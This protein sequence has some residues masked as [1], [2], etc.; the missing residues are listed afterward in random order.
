MPLHLKGLKV[1]LGKFLNARHAN[2]AKFRQRSTY[3]RTQLMHHEKWK[4]YTVYIQSYIQSRSCIC[5]IHQHSI[6]YNVILCNK[7]HLFQL[8]YHSWLI[9]T[10]S[11]T[12][13]A[14]KLLTAEQPLQRRLFHTHASVCS[15]LHKGLISLTWLTICMQ[16]DC[17]CAHCTSLK[18][19]IPHRQS[20]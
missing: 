18:M 4:A 11:K 12:L 8:Q 20:S 13:H 19:K 10:S 1:S 5:L 3:M 14:R 2:T 7:M 17:S 16:S 6:L 9:Y 15:S